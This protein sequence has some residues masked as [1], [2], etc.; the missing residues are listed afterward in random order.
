[1]LGRGPRER[2]D[3]RHPWEASE[4]IVAVGELV[5]GR[6]RIVCRLGGG[7]MGEVFEALDLELGVSVALKVLRVPLGESDESGSRFKREVLLARRV[8]HPNVCRLFDLGVHR[9]GTG[10]P[11]RR[12][13]TLELVRGETLAARL[14]RVGALEPA[15]ALP[16]VRQ[17]AA[18]L[19]AAHA[20]GVV[21]RDLKSGNVLLEEV[22]LGQPP[23]AVITDFG[24]ARGL[25]GVSAPPDAL[26]LT[27]TG[28]LLGTPAYMSPEQVEGRPAGPASDLYSLGV[29]LYE[30][31]TG[32][33]PFVGASPI[34]AALKRLTEPP[35]RPRTL[36]PGVDPVWEAAILRCLE[37]DPD[38]RFASPTDLVRALDGQSVAPPSGRRR[39]RLVGWAVAAGVALLAMLG[40]GVMLAPWLARRAAAPPAQSSPRTPRETVAV[41]GF[42]NLAGRPESAWL[43]SALAEMLTTEVAAGGGVRAIP[44]ENVARMKLE[45]A[46]A[47]PDSLAPDTL[48]RVR[49]NL[50]ADRVVLGGFAALGPESGGRLRLDIRVQRT[51]GGEVQALRFEGREAELFELVGRAG[52][53]LREVLGVSA[54][55]ADQEG[56]RRASLP[57]SPEAARLYAEGLASL[58]RFDAPSARALLE[59]ACEADP[60]FAP[61]RAALARSLNM[62]GYD[63]KAAEEARRAAEDTSG[64]PREEA[65]AIVGM[66]HEVT[67]EWSAAVESYRELRRVAPDDLEAGLRLAWVQIRAGDAEGSLATIVELR[68]LSAAAAGDPRL[69]QVAA[70]AYGDLGRN[71]ERLQAALAAG[72]RA[73]EVGATIILA[74]ARMEEGAA[75]RRLGR[76]DLARGAFEEARR[77]FERAGD[78]VAAAEALVPLGTL[79]RQE[80][81]LAG[82][83][84]LYTEAYDACMAAGSPVRA[85]RARFY[86]ALALADSGKVEEAEQIYEQALV[87]FREAGDKQ[88]AVAT[89]SNVGTMRYLRGDLAGAAA[90]HEEGRALAR[91]LGNRSREISSL[92][93]LGAIRLDGGETGAAIA[94]DDEAIA[95]AR[96]LGDR[97]LE[98]RALW[99][100][101][102]ALRVAGRAGEAR[103][104]CEG[105]LVRLEAEK[106]LASIAGVKRELAVLALDRGAPSEA[107]PLARAATDALT[108]AG[109]AGD[110]AEAG[111]TLAWA[112][113]AAGDRSAPEALAAAVAQLADNE[114]LRPRLAVDAARARLAAVDGRRDQAVRAWR[115]LAA[116]GRTLGLVLQ[117]LEAEIEAAGLE[118]GLGRAKASEALNKAAAE[119]ERRGLMAL[120]ARARSLAAGPLAKRPGAPVGAG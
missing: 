55:S 66:R 25:D 2:M 71:A 47:E 117:A 78:R 95:L 73:R 14:R 39:R 49:D 68:G 79:L 6:Y 80:G 18:G 30:M 62:L 120:A 52:S 110:A 114:E 92:L 32:E 42:R 16:I 107:V 65:L 91:E 19:E 44:G 119:A 85:A 7:A 45:L 116:E 101:C 35:P 94:A 77:I 90:R 115:R 15:E 5:A 102:A 10:G 48:A 84:R 58:R 8:T 67:R 36:R 29:M 76:R 88:A 60:Q 31:V 46:L 70:E 23:R 96:E 87:V 9:P 69:D 50:G 83:T 98:G 11:P 51:G 61:A 99:N 56:A 22:A 1:M 33:L 72:K 21:H 105:A 20:A 3:E 27:A 40:G 41:L 97:Q 113:A 108:A 24:L 100:R 38:D 86:V 106:E 74:N 28:G 103:A 57:R 26:T 43:G 54:L 118:R 63:T 59:R 53:G 104:D 37:R 89:L 13:L 64:L 17:V 111:A 75:Q 4:A 93:N 82:A 112:L 34:S 12:F 109:F 81:D